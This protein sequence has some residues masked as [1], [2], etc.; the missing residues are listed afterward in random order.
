MKK[1]LFLAAGLMLAASTAGCA[2][3][4]QALQA[5]GTV[6]VTNAKAAND[7]IIEA[8]K[9]ALCGLP[10]SAIARH[11]ELIPAIKSLCLSPGDTRAA[12]L[13]DAAAAAGSNIAAS[14][15]QVVK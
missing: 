3:V 14:A 9:V 6:A 10:L 11:P 13:L 4:S 2:G 5:Y 15:A 7:T 8:Q 1:I 12:A